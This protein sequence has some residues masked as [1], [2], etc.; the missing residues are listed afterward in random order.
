MCQRKAIDTNSH[1]SYND[2]YI[3]LTIFIWQRDDSSIHHPYNLNYMDKIQLK[4]T[5]WHKDRNWLLCRNVYQQKIWHYNMWDFWQPSFFIWNYTISFDCKLTI[6]YGHFQLLHS[7][8]NT[9][10]E[11]LLPYN[12][13]GFAFT[14][15]TEDLTKPL[16]STLELEACHSLTTCIVVRQLLS[17]IWFLH[18]YTWRYVYEQRKKSFKD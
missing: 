1:W 3:H 5:L 14:W 17:W 4:N 16:G 18:P 7:H 6:Y 10:L 11:S 2:S 8:K 12:S 9:I 15:N 13:Y